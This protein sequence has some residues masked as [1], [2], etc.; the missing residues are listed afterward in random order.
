M[1]DEG[2]KEEKEEKRE[3]R[4]VLM[5]PLSHAIV[6]RGWRGIFKRRLL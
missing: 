2:K 5:S 1:D 3:G 6:F 4:R